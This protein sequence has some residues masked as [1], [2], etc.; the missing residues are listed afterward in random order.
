MEINSLLPIIFV[1]IG[2][3]FVILSIP[4]ILEKIPPNGLYGFRTE[5]TRSDPKIW[6][7]ANKDLGN[8]LVFVGIITIICNVI[9]FLISGSLDIAS[10]TIIGLITIVLP[11]LI[12]LGM[13]INY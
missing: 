9:L 1:L 13:T 6:Y 4:L 10:I 7:K 2:L 12:V 3:F 5:K 11:L 8:K